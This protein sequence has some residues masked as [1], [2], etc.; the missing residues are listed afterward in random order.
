MIESPSMTRRL[1]VLVAL[2]ALAATASADKAKAKKASPTKAA[3]APAQ[4]PADEQPDDAPVDDGSAEDGSAALPEGVTAG[5]ALIDL[6]NDTEID[7]PAGVFF[8][9]RQHTREDLQ[10]DGDTA[11]NVQGMV[12]SPG[13][14]TVYIEYNGDG[15]VSDTDANELDPNALFQ[16][17]QQG[18][19]QQNEK[20]RALGRPELFLDGWSEMPKYTAS[21]HHL[22]WG[23]RGHDET[24]QVVNFFTKVLGRNGYMSLDLVADAANIEQAKVDAAGVLAAV[25]FKPGFTYEDHKSGDKSSGMGLKALVIGGAGL[26]VFK[27]AKGGVLVKILAVAWKGI[28]VAFAAI[29][30]FFK[31]IFRRGGSKTQLP[32]D[33]PPVG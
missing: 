21:T 10:K 14:W 5:P 7:V 3:K 8:V 20:R 33:G 15:Y 1:G 6:G 22:V 9:D 2:C 13:N 29:G 18:N 4:A 30:A 25:R 28:L 17:Y 12:I 32:P 11:E 27:V 23:L 31:K 16:S 26:A 19:I 24:G